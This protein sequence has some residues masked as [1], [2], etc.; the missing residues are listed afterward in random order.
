M[1]NREL[2][3]LNT[4]EIA[5]VLRPFVPGSVFESDN[6]LLSSISTYIN[7]LERWNARTN[8]TAIRNSRQMLTRHFGES[9]FAAHQLLDRDA[10]CKVIDLGSGAGFPGLPLKLWAPRLGLTLIESQNKKATFLR[11]VVRALELKDVEVYCGRGESYG[12]KADLV[13]MRAVEK[14]EDALQV[15]AGLVNDAGCLGVL[16]S[17]SQVQTAERM[18]GGFRCEAIAMPSGIG[19]PSGRVLVVARRK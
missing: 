18:L 2:C 4:S 13:T 10:E 15:T 16:I 14:F 6:S 17:S 7:I 8:L 9:L 19:E 12:G 1:L 5:E 3:M 11:E